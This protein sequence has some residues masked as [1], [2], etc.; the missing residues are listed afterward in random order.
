MKEYSWT[1]RRDAAS[2]M[3]VVVKRY[4]TTT[5]NHT[6]GER[7]LWEEGRSVSLP[8]HYWFTCLT[9]FDLCGM[10]WYH[11][12]SLRFVYARFAL[13]WAIRHRF[14]SS[15]ARRNS[16][17]IRYESLEIAVALMKKK[18]RFCLLASIC[19]K[20]RS[21]PFTSKRNRWEKK[22][23]LREK[24]EIFAWIFSNSTSIGSYSDYCINLLFCIRPHHHHRLSMARISQAYHH[25]ITLMRTTEVRFKGD[26]ISQSPN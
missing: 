15:S 10:M 23:K 12:L 21:T 20:T 5:A 6:W 9:C 2:V 18:P 14:F 13:R 7:E 24:T 17:S 19:W 16:Q 25:K 22:R 8:Q 11:H 4:L 3:L 26:G 1:V